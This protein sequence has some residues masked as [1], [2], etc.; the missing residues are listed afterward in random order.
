MRRV[1]LL[2]GVAVVLALILVNDLRPDQLH[3]ATSAVVPAVT[4]SSGLPGR[5]TATPP[6]ATAFARPT[7]QLTPLVT[8]PFMF[9]TRISPTPA[10]D[11]T[12]V[13]PLA[14]VER[15]AFGRTTTTQLEASFG[16]AVYHG[17]RP[18]RLRFEDKSCVLIV[19][20][21]TQ[22]ALEAELVN[23]GSL[24]LLLDRYGS[25]EAVGISLGNLTLLTIGNAVLLYPEQ[26]VIAVFDA[27][28]D[29]LDRAMP[30]S[31]L[32]FRPPYAAEKQI[33]RLNLRPVENWQPPLR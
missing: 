33:T 8:S 12:S 7:V 23:Y 22:E 9:S 24:G 13:F 10:D 25:P 19:T 14:S 32:H 17:G 6:R 15:I 27:G 30:V 18:P 1:L 3:S 4:S 5:S 2:T 31:H 16:R 21:G 11:C 20:L 26:G 28:P 29:D